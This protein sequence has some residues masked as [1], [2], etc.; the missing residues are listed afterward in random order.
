MQIPH[1]K[2]R[3]HNKDIGYKG[4][5]LGNKLAS[6]QGGQGT[7]NYHGHDKKFIAGNI[8]DVKSGGI[9][10]GIYRKRFLARMALP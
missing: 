8:E 7:K 3:K 2:A 6:R 9:V 1:T 4:W 10:R 5:D